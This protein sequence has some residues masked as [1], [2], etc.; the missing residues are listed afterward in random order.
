MTHLWSSSFRVHDLNVCRRTKKMKGMQQSQ[1]IFEVE[2][3]VLPDWLRPCHRNCYQCKF[4]LWLLA[5]IYFGWWLHQGIWIVSLSPGSLFELSSCRVS[6]VDEAWWNLFLSW[7]GHSQLPLI[8]GGT[9]WPWTYGLN[10][11]S[12]N[13]IP[14]ICSK[15]LCPVVPCQHQPL[16]SFSM[17]SENKVLRWV[18]HKRIEK[19][20][21]TCPSDA[22]VEAVRLQE[23]YF[24]SEPDIPLKH[25]YTH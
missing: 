20:L 6:W 2:L 8:S 7:P 18:R 4:L 23:C 14:Y 22:Q 3:F 16:L 10:H 24:S 15:V 21:C 11:F 9:P 1:F 25:I 12:G 19:A 5:W 17:P 13:S